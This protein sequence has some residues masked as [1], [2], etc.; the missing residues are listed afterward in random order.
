M[1]KTL[2]N[3]IPNDMPHDIQ[4]FVSGANIY[5]TSCS[6]KAK[7]Y[8]IDKGNGYYLKCSDRGMLEKESQ[9]TEYFYSKGFGAEVLNYISNN[10]DWLLTTA[11]IGEDCVHE[12]YLMDPKRLCDTIAYELRKLHETDYSDCPIPDR[13]AEYLAGAEKNY[14]TGNYH[15]SHFPDR[16]GYRSAKEAYDVLVAGKD[17]L[18]SKVLLHGDYCLPNII[19]NNWNLSGF[20]DVGN[21]GVGDRHIDI[22]WGVWSLGFNL[23]TN[24]YHERF[25]DAYGRDKADESIL[26]IVAAAEVFG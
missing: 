12:R 9:M 10:S 3:R 16:F 5:D 14:C 26:K 17:A 8:F 11:V 7:V 20:I 19:L 23:K 1:K 18:Q 15:K 4:R 13:T 2:L 24:K 22:F 25:L 21:G 6:P